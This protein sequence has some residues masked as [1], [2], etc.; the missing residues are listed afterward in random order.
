[1]DSPAEPSAAAVDHVTGH[2]GTGPCLVLSAGAGAIVEA[3]ANRGIPVHGVE[4]D[5]DRVLVGLSRRVDI[6]SGDLLAYLFGSD[7]GEF[8]TIVLTGKVETLPLKDLLGMADQASRKLMKTGQIIVAVADPATRGKVDSELGS[9]LGISPVTW[10]HLLERI[11]FDARL[12]PCPD[13]RITEIVVAQR[14]DGLN[15][16]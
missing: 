10:R 9:G 13:S 7:D 2:V 5:P 11:G 3:V 6:R 12:E 4:Q 16:P 15:Q 8:G 1:M 14:T